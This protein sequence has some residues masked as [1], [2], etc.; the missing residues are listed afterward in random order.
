[1]KPIGFEGGNMEMVSA[2]SKDADLDT[3]GFVVRQC[4]M[5]FFAMGL[6]NVPLQQSTNLPTLM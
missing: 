4:L 6:M 5:A 3:P 1:M 2:L